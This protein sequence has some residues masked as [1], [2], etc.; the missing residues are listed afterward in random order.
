M[1]FAT[2]VE[3]LIEVSTSTGIILDTA[4]TLKTYQ[5]MMYMMK[6]TPERFKGNRVLFLHTGM[7]YSYSIAGIVIAVLKL[8]FYFYLG[9]LY[10]LKG[11]DEILLNSEETN[12]VRHIE[13]FVIV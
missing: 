11:L 1:M 7:Q 13:D 2:I 10:G 5:I 6:E 4:F 8:I 3:L 9:G 12:K